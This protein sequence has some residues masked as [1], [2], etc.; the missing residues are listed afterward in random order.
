MVDVVAPIS[1]SIALSQTLWDDIYRTSAS[2]S[3][4]VYFRSSLVLIVPAHR[5][6][7]RLS[8]LDRPVTHRGGFP[9]CRWWITHLYTCMQH[10]IR[11]TRSNYM[12][13]ETI[14]LWCVILQLRSFT[15]VFARVCMS[16][17]TLQY[18]WLCKCGC[19]D[20]E[21]HPQ[22]EEYWG[23]V[24]PN[25]PTACH[26]EGKRIAETLSYAYEKQVFLF[27]VSFVIVKCGNLF[28]CKK[29]SNKLSTLCRWEH[30]TLL[31]VLV[32]YIAKLMLSLQ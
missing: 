12:S 5:G 18:V 9:G 13:A 19:L 17:S 3:V 25:G 6:M 22:T 2:S 32:T 14:G 24:N 21:E 27:C 31:P 7:A 15:I 4:P 8:W 28:V 29:L 23:R 26:D 11:M 10:K 1:I 30:W 20:P 16:Y